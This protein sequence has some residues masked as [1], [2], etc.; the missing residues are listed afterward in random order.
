MPS[1]AGQALVEFSLATG[2]GV[3]LV[4]GV[5]KLLHSAWIQ[6]GCA[7]LAFEATHARVTGRLGHDRNRFGKVQ[8]EETNEFVR[9]TLNCE[10][11]KEVVLLPRLSAARW[12]FRD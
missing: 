10:G 6:T 8:F 3:L 11:F 5:G 9:G 1:P 12:D 2:I 4:F 7:H